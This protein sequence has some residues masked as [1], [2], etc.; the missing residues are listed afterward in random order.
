MKK[1]VHFLAFALLAGSAQAQC[2]DLFFSE[3]IEGTSDNKALEIYNPTSSGIDLSDYRVYRYANGSPTP[4]DTLHPV[5]IIAAGDV[6]VIANPDPTPGPDPQILAEEDTLHTVTFYNGDDAISLYKISTTT[7]IDVIG[8]IGVDPG[9]N[10]TVGLGAT[11]EYTLVR[12]SNIQQGTTNWTVGQTQWDVFPQNMF[13]SLGTHTMIA[14][15]A[16][17]TNTFAA[18]SPVECDSYTAPDGA[19]YTNSGIYTAT[20]PNTQGCDSIITIDLTIN[21]S[22][23]STISVSDC[24]SVSVNGTTYNFSGSYTQ[25]LTNSVNCDSILTVNVDITNTPAPPVVNGTLDYCEGDTPTAL[26]VESSSTDSLIITGV[27]DATLSGGQPKALELYVIEDIADLSAYALGAANN[28]GGSDGIEYTFPAVSVTAGTFIH[29][30]SDSNDFFTWMGYYPDY[31]GGSAVGINGDDAIE[32]FH[33]GA[34][35]DVFGDI[36][37]DGTGEPWEYQDGW[38]YRKINSAPNGGTF[39]LGEWDFSGINVLDGAGTNSNASNPFPDETY[40]F[41]PQTIT[42]NWYDDAGLT[43]LV[44]TGNSL[45]PGITTG[46]ISYYVTAES[47]GGS[48]CTSDATQ[49]DVTFNAPPTV[50]ANASSTDV[51]EGENVTLTGSGADTYQWDNGVTDGVAFAATATED[52]IVTG[53]DQNG[54]SAADTVTITVTL[55]PT[56]SLSALSTVCNTDAAFTLTGGTP[57][58]GT[59]SGTGVSGGDFDPAAAGPGTFTITYEYTDGSSGCTGSATADITVQDCANIEELLNGGMVIYPNPATD[60]LTVA[61]EA[62][63]TALQIVDLSGVQVA[64]ADTNTISVANLATG[65]YVINITTNAGQVT[66]TFVKK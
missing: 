7:I 55:A 37:V 15:G 4:T 27:L 13:D 36:N 46:S 58:G 59:Y 34:V 56:V 44:G 9:T 32:L 20:I 29:I 66:K 30:A 45:T 50:V 6:Y 21:N 22:T 17:C 31:L 65:M 64:N 18:I 54:C 5:G 35:I 24:D 40:S 38:A 33:N 11:S 43:N 60:V 41:T 42:I 3:Y 26:I 25:V 19:T 39:V 62:N 52:Y 8:E 57:A 49:V 10:W 47:T 16:P 1:I 61:S 23:S 51:C 28:G 12:S 63:V 2:T 48:T 14:C 53:T